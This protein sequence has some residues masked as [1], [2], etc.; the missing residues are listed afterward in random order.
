MPLYSAVCRHGH[1]Q[2]FYAKIADRDDLRPCDSCSSPL[3]RVIDAPYVKP[4]IAPYQSP[5][6]GEWVNSRAQRKEDLLRSGSLEW[7]PG[8]KQ[9]I[10]R[11]RQE[12]FE[13]SLAPM[14]KT[15][16]DTARDLVASGSLPPL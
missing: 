4:D 11:R 5:V 1:R 9:D 15:I 7:D 6:T 14:E 8:L 13:Q 16:E 2:V 3:T 10:T 12:L